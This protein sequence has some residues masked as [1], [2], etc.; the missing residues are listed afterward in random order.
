M[1][2]HILC[3]SV[4]RK[5]CCQKEQRT[6]PVVTKEQSALHADK[7]SN[8]WVGNLIVVAALLVIVACPA[9]SWSTNIITILFSTV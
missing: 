4:N 7:L 5:C 6:L 8:H 2:V 3:I 9:W 1:I